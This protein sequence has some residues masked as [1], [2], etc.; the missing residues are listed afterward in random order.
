MWAQ[1]ALTT[2]D[3][4]NI[5]KKLKEGGF[6]SV[7]LF[8]RA[9]KQILMGLEQNWS[10]FNTALGENAHIITLLDMEN[11][12]DRVSLK[13]PDS[14]ESS[15]GEFCNKLKIRL[16]E[17][18]ALVLLNGHS[19]QF[20]EVPYWSLQKGG[21][22]ENSA[23]LVSLVGDMQSATETPPPSDEAA[24]TVWLQQATTQLIR[25]A[26]GREMKWIIQKNSKFLVSALKALLNSMVS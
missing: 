9:D 20:V 7:L 8:R 1:P 15:V 3:L 5:D 2:N 24:K 17:L 26:S 13:F 21:M 19:E 11:T 14:Y 4:K 23:A 18:P 22:K 16:D 10:A 25:S 6:W 12:G